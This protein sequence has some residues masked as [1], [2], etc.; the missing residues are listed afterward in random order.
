MPAESCD[1]DHVVAFDHADPL[2]GGWTLPADLIPLFRPDHQRKHLGIWRPTL[3]TDRTV[4]WRHR[5]T[6]QTIVTHPR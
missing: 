1:L 5:D 4:T 3:H 6:G 2:A